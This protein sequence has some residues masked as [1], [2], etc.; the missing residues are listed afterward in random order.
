MALADHTRSS[1]SRPATAPV[2]EP[3]SPVTDAPDTHSLPGN[4]PRPTAQATG[5]TIEE[6]EEEAVDSEIKGEE[7]GPSPIQI[8]SKLPSVNDPIDNV[9]Q[10]RPVPPFPWASFPYESPYA[11]YTTVAILCSIFFL[12]LTSLSTK[13]YCCVI[14]TL[15]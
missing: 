12:F 14:T 10:P 9:R 8:S 5:L 15:L 2:D 3:T 1:R 4:L 11:P 13:V 7:P 6:L